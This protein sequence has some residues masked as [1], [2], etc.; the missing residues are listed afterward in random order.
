MFNKKLKIENVDACIMTVDM[1]KVFGLVQAS[2][3]IDQARSAQSILNAKYFI[4]TGIAPSRSK[5]LIS[6][7]LRI[8]EFYQDIE[9]LPSVCQKVGDSLSI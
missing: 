7:I 3:N 5:G 8:K 1:V 2:M 6:Y 4:P 9:L